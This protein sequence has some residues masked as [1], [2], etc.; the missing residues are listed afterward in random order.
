MCLPY[1]SSNIFRLDDHESWSFE[2]Y[3]NLMLYQPC[4]PMRRCGSFLMTPGWSYVSF[5]AVACHARNQLWWS[6]VLRQGNLRIPPIWGSFQRE[7]S[8]CNLS[9]HERLFM[10]CEPAPMVCHD[11]WS[12]AWPCLSCFFARSN[13]STTWFSDVVCH[14][15]S[16]TGQSNPSVTPNDWQWETPKIESFCPKKG[17]WEESWIYDACKV[18]T[19]FWF[20]NTIKKPC[21]ARRA[22]GETSTLK[23]LWCA[24]W[25]F[26]RR[27]ACW[28][29]AL[30]KWQVHISLEDPSTVDKR[31]VADWKTLASIQKLQFWLDGGW[32]PC[33]HLDFTEATHPGK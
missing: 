30:K 7:K 17:D 22:T 23:R 5:G 16:S 29:P 18:S 12:Q 24:W 32:I 9:K 31:D 26:S 8:F 15:E 33:C 21:E 13:A 20:W 28:W 25:T 14:G 4:D 19:Q 6:N 11:W 1:V 3:W 10:D 2:G 27:W